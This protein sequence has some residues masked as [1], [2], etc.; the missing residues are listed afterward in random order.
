MAT[1]AAKRKTSV[2]PWVA[3]LGAVLVALALV[4]VFKAFERVS[5]REIPPIEAISFER[6]ILSE[7][8]IELLLRNDGPDPVRIAQVLVNDAYWLFEIT[9]ADLGRLET[10]TMTIPYPWEEGLPLRIALITS[11]GVTIDHELEAAAET[12]A[13]GADTFLTYA[14]LGIYVGVIPVAI[15][16]LSFPFLRN[17]SAR[18]LGF[19]LGLTLGLLAFLLVDTVA[20][21]F[22]LAAQAAAALNGLGLFFIGALL[23]L[24]TLFWFE[25]WLGRKRGSQGTTGLALAYLIATGIGLH[26]MGE[27]VAIGAALATGEVALGV[28]LVA[29]FAL[30]NTTE[31]LAIVSP[32]GGTGSRPS[33]WHFVALGAVAGVPTIFGAWIGGFAFSPAWAS[34]AFGVAAGAIVQVIWA[35]SKSMKGE[36]SMSHGLP[37]LGFFAGLGVMYLTGLLT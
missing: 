36:A 27:G 23:A 19:F 28:F 15:G 30:H 2:K 6:T 3:V 18:W 22:E 10:S 35:I 37:A 4:G 21:G 8:E 32:L 1:S 7:G 34:L 16:L 25:G 13:V 33:L 5:L 11:T 26:N 24:V 14:L 17:M 20:E 29:G 12:P 31:G 9:D